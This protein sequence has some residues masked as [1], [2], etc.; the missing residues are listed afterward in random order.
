MLPYLAQGANQALE[1]AASLEYF[2]RP[3]SAFNIFEAL[4]LYSEFRRDRVLMVQKFSCRN[5]KLYHLSNGPVTALKHKTLNLV[6]RVLPNFLLGRFDWLYNY[7][8][9][10]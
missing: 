3:K 1:D 4:E 8:A 5:A 9:P 7:E 6:S 2:L 10:S